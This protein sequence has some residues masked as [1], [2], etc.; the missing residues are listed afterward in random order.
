VHVNPP[1]IAYGKRYMSEHA[2]NWLERLEAERLRVEKNTIDREARERADARKRLKKP[3]TA[4]EDRLHKMRLEYKR[5][6]I[7]IDF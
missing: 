1:R 3:R 7:K 2:N 4:D 6:G 5:L